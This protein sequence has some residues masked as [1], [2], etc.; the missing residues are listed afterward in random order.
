MKYQVHTVGAVASAFGII[1]LSNK[2]EFPFYKKK[3]SYGNSKK[4]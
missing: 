2:M 3:I 1:Y 4:G